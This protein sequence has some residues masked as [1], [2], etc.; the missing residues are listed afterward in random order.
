MIMDRFRRSKPR[1]HLMTRVLI[2]VLLLAGLATPAMGPA[3]MAHQDLGQPLDLAAMALTPD[4]L[5]SAGMPGFG[6]GVSVLG[7]A[8]TVGS[9]LAAWREDPQGTLGRVL[10]TAAPSRIHL[11]WMGQPVEAGNPDSDTA[12]FVFS[13]AFE[14]PDDAAAAQGFATLA[15]GWETGNARAEPIGATVGQQSAFF[16][17]RG[18]DPATGFPY[19]RA[20]LIFLHGRLVGGISLEDATGETPSE[21]LMVSLAQRLD[22][23]MGLVL[24][25][26]PPGLST[27]IVRLALPNG[28]EDV[29]LLSSDRYEVV[30]GSV[31]RRVGETDEELANRQ[32]E[33]EAIGLTH[34]YIM[35][36]PTHG[37]TNDPDLLFLDHVRQFE[38][39]QAAAAWSQAELAGLAERGNTDVQQVASTTLG[40]S[41][42]LTTYLNSS[43][44]PTFRAD[45]QQGP[46]VSTLLFRGSVLADQALVETVAAAQLAC[47]AQGQCLEPL[48]PSSTPDPVEGIRGRRGE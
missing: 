4:D 42:M 22:Q 40:D 19:L 30:D 23:R 14:F 5:T 41:A 44:R 39:A 48:S 20:D 1:M 45:I 6:T 47:F 34:Y 10:E 46:M 26:N 9:F 43:G 36:Q 13:Y 2:G 7:E 21:N 29:F 28:F 31:I 15:G 3:A 16:R 24:A 25:G 33:Y 32:T 18:Q 37:L 27:M 17:D 12:R 38:S 8:P 35:G 11:L